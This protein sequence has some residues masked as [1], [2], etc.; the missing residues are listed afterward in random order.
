MRTT[1]VRSACMYSQYLLQY[2]SPVYSGHAASWSS[3]IKF[4]ICKTVLK[5][6]NK[7]HPCFGLLNDLAIEAI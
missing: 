2:K 1:T 6:L 7:L 5:G 3:V 4:K